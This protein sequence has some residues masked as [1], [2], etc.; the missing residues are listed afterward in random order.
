MPAYDEGRDTTLTTPTTIISGLTV[1][2]V[3]AAALSAHLKHHD[4][5]AL[6]PDMSD[7]EKLAILTEE[8]GEV[9]HELTYDAHGVAD[10]WG[11]RR[12]RLERELLQVAAVALTWIESLNTPVDPYADMTMRDVD[13]GWVAQCEREDD[14]AER[15]YEPPQ[16]DDGPF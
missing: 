8:V 10:D 5:T 16:G 11:E 9:A 3:Q 4:H 7:L 13:P 1:S 6:N 2:A 14:D 15:A 12:V